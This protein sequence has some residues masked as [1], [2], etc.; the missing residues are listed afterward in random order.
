[1]DFHLL[2]YKRETKQVENVY[3]ESPFMGHGAADNVMDDFKRV[4]EELDIINNLVQLLMDGPNISWAFRNVLENCRKEEDPN[5]IH[6][7]HGAY[8]KRTQ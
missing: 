6:V 7:L 8:K 1:M 4:H 3:L 2:C 5:A